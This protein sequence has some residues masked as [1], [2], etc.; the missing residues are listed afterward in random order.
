MAAIPP[1]TNLP[2]QYSPPQTA[3]AHGGVPHHDRAIA[4]QYAKSGG[5]MPQNHIQRG[6]SPQPAMHKSS[7]KKKGYSQ[8]PN[9]PAADVEQSDHRYGGNPLSCPLSCL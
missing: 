7:T 8:S 3:Q 2:H 6:V 5:G 1:P 9:R 4:N